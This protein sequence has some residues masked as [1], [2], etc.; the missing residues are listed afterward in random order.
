LGELNGNLY[1]V[2]YYI[3]KSMIVAGGLYIIICLLNCVV[4]Y[5][6]FIE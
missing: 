1:S 6:G 2:I 4:G 3:R 5:N